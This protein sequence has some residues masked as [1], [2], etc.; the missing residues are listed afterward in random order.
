MAQTSY[1]ETEIRKALSNSLNKFSMDVMKLPMPNET[2]IQ[3]YKLALRL[4]KLI[5]NNLGI[6]SEKMLETINQ[7]RSNL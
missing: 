3:I 1:S 2:K 7:K 4:I 5:F 6:S